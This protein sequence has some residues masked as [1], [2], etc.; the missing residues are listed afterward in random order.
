MNWSNQIFDL[1]GVLNRKAPFGRCNMD[2]DS[3]FMIYHKTLLASA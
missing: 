1:I 2:R 3:T